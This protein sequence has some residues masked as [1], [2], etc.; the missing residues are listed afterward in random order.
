[1]CHPWRR[2]LLG[3]DVYLNSFKRSGVSGTEETARRFDLCALLCECKQGELTKLWTITQ[4][5]ADEGVA[6][7]GPG[8]YV[9]IRG[10]FPRAFL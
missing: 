9:P 6:G 10:Q 8:F 5:K 7:A 2:L 4:R 3:K 1:M